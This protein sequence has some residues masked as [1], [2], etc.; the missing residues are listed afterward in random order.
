MDI[1]FRTTS[2]AL[3]Y[4]TISRVSD[5]WVFQRRVLDM[6]YQP[7]NEPDD[8]ALALFYLSSQYRVFSLPLSCSH[9]SPLIVIYL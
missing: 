7:V 9:S 4:P 1:Y 2:K 6:V 3:A 8:P 5:V